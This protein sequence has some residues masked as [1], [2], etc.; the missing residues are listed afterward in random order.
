[1]SCTLKSNV[2]S[3]RIHSDYEFIF[4]VEKDDL[5]TFKI[6]NKNAV[7][8]CLLQQ[9]YYDDNKQKLMNCLLKINCNSNIL[10]SFV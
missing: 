5:F 1:M 7:F 9:A 8:H 2:N 4:F 10:S 6:V 3:V